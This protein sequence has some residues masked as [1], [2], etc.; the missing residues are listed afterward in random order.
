MPQGELG[1]HSKITERVREDA[2]FDQRAE[3]KDE[4]EQILEEK[5]LLQKDRRQ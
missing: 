4:N 5:R 2:E 1:G 3:L